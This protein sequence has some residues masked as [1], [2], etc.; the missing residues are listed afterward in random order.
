MDC[1][2]LGAQLLGAAIAGAALLGF[3]GEANAAYAVNGM[4]SIARTALDC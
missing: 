4:V 3:Y 2:V 1:T